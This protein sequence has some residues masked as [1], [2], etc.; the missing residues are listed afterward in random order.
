ME[1]GKCAPIEVEKCIVGVPND[2][3]K[4]SQCVDKFYAHEE[5]SCEQIT[6]KNCKSSN[7]SKSAVKCDTCLDG[8]VLSVKQ[9]ACSALPQGCLMAHFDATVQCIQCNSLEKYFATDVK[10]DKVVSDTN[11]WEQVCTK[12]SAAKIAALSLVAFVFGASFF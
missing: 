2:P 12:T 6:V 5:T 11:R 9:D 1:D 7:Q 3:K 10:G 8:F 4:C